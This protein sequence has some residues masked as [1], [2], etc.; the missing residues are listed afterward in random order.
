MYGIEVAQSWTM[1]DVWY[2]YGACSDKYSGVASQKERSVANFS[3]YAVDMCP[4]NK[5]PKTG[6]AGALRPLLAVTIFA[7]TLAVSAQW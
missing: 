2:S 7:A 6:D 3:Q 5:D 1:T 4:W